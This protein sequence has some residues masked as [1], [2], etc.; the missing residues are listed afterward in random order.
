MWGR[1]E[2]LRFGALLMRLYRC[3][4]D[5]HGSARGIALAIGNF[6]GFHVGHQAVIASMQEKAKRL[7]LESAVMIF[8]PQPMEFFGK[9]VPARLFTIRDKLRIFRAAGV[10][11][12]FCMNFTRKFANLTDREFVS[13]LHAPLNVK[14]VTVG[15]QFNFGK[16]GAYDFADLQR[17]CQQ[18]GIESSAIPKVED[19]GVRVSSTLLRSLIAQ[20][21][22]STMAKFM[23]HPYSISGRVVHGNAIGRTIGFPTANINLNRRVCPLNGVYAVKVNCSYGTFEGVANVGHRPTVAKTL[24]SLLE[25]NIFNFNHDLYGQEIE[26][27]FVHKIRDESKFA[28]LEQLIAQITQDKE[29]AKY[30]L[31]L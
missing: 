29:R 30:L 11:I 16:A 8:E 3:L 2:K 20:G 22:F 4:S 13:M 18:L 17:C 25:V 31:T 19:A 1:K 26:V 27:T 14:S 21:D 15:S 24:H 23:G 7:N 10:D 6:D 12:V 9:K 5:F 28:G